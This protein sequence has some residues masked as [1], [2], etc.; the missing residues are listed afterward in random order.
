MKKIILIFIFIFQA[1]SL[2]AFA[3]TTLLK[4]D[5]EN[6]NNFDILKLYFDIAPKYSIHQTGR[7]IDVILNNTL[8]NN[9][10]LHFPTDASIVKFLP[11]VGENQ[12]TLSFFLRYK[13][14]HVS[15]SPGKNSSL[16]VTIHLGSDSFKTDTDIVSDLERSQPGSNANDRLANPL[17]LSPYKDDWRLFFSRYESKVSIKVPVH[18]TLPP[19]PI[20]GFLPPDYKKN[21]RLI[22]SQM[23]DLVQTKQWNA[24]VPLVTDLL[25][26][27]SNVEKKKKL[28]LTY[29]EILLRAG[30]FNGAY[31]QLYLLKHTYPHESIR[32]LADFL[33]AELQATY[34]DPNLSDYNLQLLAPSIKNDS[35]LAPYILLLRIETALATHQL[36][37][38]K[39]LLDRDDIHFPKSIEKIREMRQA[40]Y[41]YAKGNMIKAYVGYQ[42]L[43]D[44]ALIEHH[45]YS[46]NGYCDTL[47]Q[48]QRFRDSAKCYQKLADRLTDKGRLGMAEY[49]RAMSELH[50][51]KN[52]D[53]L[54][55]FSTLA[56]AF[57]DS[58][59]GYKSAIKRNDIRFLTKKD[60]EAQTSRSYGQIAQ[61]ATN[62]D[63]SEE[64]AFKEALVY[65]LMGKEPKS[66]RLLMTFLR[67]YRSGDL[68][69]TAQALLLDMLPGELHRLMR[70]KLYVEALV[71]AKQNDMFFRR[72]WLNPG[73]LADIASA[74]RHLDLFQEAENTYLYL[75]DIEG[76]N[77]EEKYFLP[78]IQAAYS[79]GHYRVVDTYA[80][81]YEHK[82]PSGKNSRMILLLHLQALN[83]ENR[84]DQAL[85]LLPSPLPADSKFQ[86]LAADLYY[87]NDDFKKV[88]KI[89]SPLH[90]KGKLHQAASLLILAESLNSQQEYSKAEPIYATLEKSATFSDQVRFRLANIALK[91]G[92][93]EKAV[94]LLKQIVDKGN[95][96]LWKNLAQKTLDYE[97]II[98]SSP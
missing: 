7:R 68:I 76:K 77:A 54:T 95:D 42:I 59:A 5:R 32:L 9:S 35:P 63:T 27:T 41:W 51:K 46:L 8:M 57:P 73:L 55:Q 19:F 22:P 34:Q 65:K 23:N 64:A 60:W 45:T 82:F 49:R 33:L 70:E 40:D 28:A 50:F 80:A 85:T 87:K 18:F 58:N 79:Q 20:I 39:T 48:Q 25:K 21:L 4:I 66:I 15:I 84:I 61:K 98:S 2:C 69:Q 37:K 26:T 16:I 78:L 89:L 92:Q 3:K 14:E 94:K 75:M 97:T 88:V 90:N 47:Y 53:L 67:N 44:P 74:Y 29:G 11:L 30:D 12:T 52:Y 72:K 1:T 96:P 13:P 62:R 17:T 31:K 24:M 91:A 6:E 93:T 81:E 83:N 10:S 86:I 36:S 56:D 38:M 43:D 71:L